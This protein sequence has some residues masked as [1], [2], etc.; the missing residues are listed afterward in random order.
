MDYQDNY[1]YTTNTQFAISGAF[2]CLIR[3]PWDSRSVTS[4]KGRQDVSVLVDAWGQVTLATGQYQTLRQKRTTSTALSVEAKVPI[5]GWF[6]VT[7]IASRDL[8]GGS[9][10]PVSAAQ[11]VF[12]K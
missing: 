3:S 12:L 8:L 7:Q 10:V 6:D 1:D 2:I 9:S 4:G 5:L 11:Y